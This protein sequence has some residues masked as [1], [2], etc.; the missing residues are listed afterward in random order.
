MPF[1]SID[2]SEYNYVLPDERIAKYPLP[3]R[4]QSK[5]LVYRQGQIEHDNFHN[6]LEYLP[7][8]SALYWN[9]TKVIPARLHFFKESGAHIEIFL[10]NPVSPSM[11]ISSAMLATRTTVWHCKIGNKK[12]WKGDQLLTLKLKTGNVSC[13]LMD[14][15]KDLVEFTWSH[16]AAFSDLL[17]EIGNVPL[18]PYLNRDAEESD[19]D[20]YQTKYA[21]TKGAVAAPT[22]GLHFS[23]KLLNKIRSNN[24]SIRELTLHVSA[25]TFQP[26]STD[27]IADHPMH[28]EQIDV[29]RTTL[30]KLKKDQFIIAVGTTSMR[31]LESLYW[32]GITLEKNPNI[33]SFN[34]DKNVPY[35]YTT[36]LTVEKS[37]D[38]IL[39]WMDLKGYT[40]ITGQTGIFIVPGY[41][42]KVVKG[43]ITNYHMPKSTLILLISAFVGDQ[44][45]Q[46]YETA[47]SENY[48]FLSFG[49]SSLLI[50]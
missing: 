23:E 9:N 41:S 43:L 6:I 26:I 31:T 16:A 42:F 50:P 47:L 11:E 13:K 5:L 4:D 28:Y 30:E 35:N 18:P 8:E 45:R 25:G 32:F 29:D 19:K 2:L 46:I 40:R 15:E 17:E 44:W 3:N 7:L 20:R 22:A 14:R 49:D 37:I 38:N 48:R 34:V 39:T 24:F 36:E 10:L 21:R 33:E 12:K 1:P 27:N